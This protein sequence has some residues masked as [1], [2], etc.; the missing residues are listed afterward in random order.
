MNKKNYF[1]PIF[2]IVLTLHLGSCKKEFIS[3]E[4]KCG[5][6]YY[7]YFEDKIPLEK[8]PT[9]IT[10]GFKENL[11][12]DQA[13][14][15]INKSGYLEPISSQNY[16]ATG[17]K[18]VRT[19][20][21][22]YRTCEDVHRILNYLKQNEEISFANQ[23]L[24]STKNKPESYLGLTDEF[25]VGLKDAQDY[26]SLEKFAKEKNVTIVR[27]SSYSELYFIR[28]DKFSDYDA[29]EMANIFQES[30]L[31]EYAAPDF[32]IIMQPL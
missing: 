26:P 29:L 32:L 31:F 21:K 10:L 12:Y 25:Y 23:D 1:L 5:S 22:G 6:S 17:Q 2:L 9:L 13:S 30:G 14:Q 7:Y 4:N 11:S 8:S 28:V 20:I 3:P 27:Q 24:Y 18:F 19:K 15:I 16:I